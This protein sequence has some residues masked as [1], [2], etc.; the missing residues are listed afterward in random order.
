MD[1]FAMQRVGD[2][3]AAVVAMGGVVLRWAAV[4]G[5]VV[6]GDGFRVL[7]GGASSNGP[8]AG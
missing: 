7:R 4:G 5:G 2:A 6:A 1:I 3:M 8:S